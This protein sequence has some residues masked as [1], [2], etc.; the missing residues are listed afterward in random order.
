MLKKVRED[1]ACLK[2]GKREKLCEEIN[3]IFTK[4][5]DRIKAVNESHFF[6]GH[7]IKMTRKGK[8]EVKIIT[9]ALSNKGDNCY[10]ELREIR[11]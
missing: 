3:K 6:F 11:K 2:G 4:D 10:F 1:C 5:E 7:E 8:Y 9:T